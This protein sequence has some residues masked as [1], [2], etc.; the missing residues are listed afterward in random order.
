MRNGHRRFATRRGF[1][2]DVSNRS[3][4][5]VSNVQDI[6]RSA[7]DGAGRAIETVKIQGKKALKAA[8]RAQIQVRDYINGNPGKSVLIALG[9]GAL[10]GFLFRGRRRQA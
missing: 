5:I 4:R 3:A 7:V 6:G 9:T 8:N 1:M 2:K 10:L